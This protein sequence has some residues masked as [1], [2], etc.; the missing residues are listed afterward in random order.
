MKRL[1][2][3][4]VLALVVVVLWALGGFLL[5]WI[6][7]QSEQGVF[8]DKFGAVNAL[9]S[10]LAFSGVIYAILLQRQ[11]LELQRE[12]LKLTR[13]ELHRSADAHTEAARV[14]TNQLR[15]SVLSSRLSASSGLLQSCNEQLAAIEA[16]YAG[17]QDMLSQVSLE[18]SS[19][20]FINKRNQIEQKVEQI[21]QELEQLEH[22]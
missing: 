20:S 14:L 12:E 18:H 2:S 9:F 22:S 6:F 7:A 16:R 13:E 19:S 21:L 5:P 1:T 11:E 8:G 15:I 17:R 3:P 4:L 10:G